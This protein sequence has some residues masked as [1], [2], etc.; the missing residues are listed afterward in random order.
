MHQPFS[1]RIATTE[2]VARQHYSTSANNHGGHAESSGIMN[3][4]D[5]AR[6]V[7]AVTERM[8]TYAPTPVPL[9]FTWHWYNSL[10][11]NRYGVPEVPGGTRVPEVRVLRHRC[12]PMPRL[13]A[14]TPYN[15][16]RGN[17]YQVRGNRSTRWYVQYPRFEYCVTQTV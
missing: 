9:H 17:R 10:R 14:L 7:Q 5:V 1:L 6:H 4:G 2:V 3:L 15:S 16:L 8:Q 11:G 13:C 12:N